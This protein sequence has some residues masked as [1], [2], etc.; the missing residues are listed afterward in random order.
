MSTVSLCATNEMYKVRLQEVISIPQ[1][2]QTNKKKPEG[3]GGGGGASF[4]SARDKVTSKQNLSG[5]N[6][7]VQVLH[8]I[9]NRLNST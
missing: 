4:L 6:R 3:G 7:P 1:N 8:F 5:M 9:I 2:K